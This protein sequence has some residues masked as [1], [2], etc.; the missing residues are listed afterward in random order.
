MLVRKGDKIDCENWGYVYLTIVEKQSGRKYSLKSPTLYP[1]LTE[2]LYTF[3]VEAR[4]VESIEL[5]F[6][7]EFNLNDDWEIGEYGIRPL[8]EEDAHVEGSI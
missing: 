4:G 5:L 8:L 6:E 7:F 1:L 2:P 3:E